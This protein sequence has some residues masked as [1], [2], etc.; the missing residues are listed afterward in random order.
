M[1]PEDLINDMIRAA[2]RTTAIQE[3]AHVVVHLSF[4]TPARAWIEYDDS[5]D[6]RFMS[7]WKGNCQSRDWRKAET[8]RMRAVAGVAGAVA[9]AMVGPGGFREDW[10]EWRADISPTDRAAIGTHSIIGA[11]RIAHGVLTHHWKAVEAIAETLEREGGVT[12]YESGEL[13]NRAM[14]IDA[15]PITMDSHL[16]MESTR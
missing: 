9:V 5:V 11:A 6:T 16:R 13:F 10:P 3:A 15:E 8:R 12:D 1:I 7:P 4:G 2:K 14:G